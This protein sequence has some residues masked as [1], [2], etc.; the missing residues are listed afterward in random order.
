[1][2]DGYTPSFWHELQGEDMI[3]RK[4]GYRNDFLKEC[5]FHEPPVSERIK[6]IRE[7]KQK[8]AL[9]EDIKNAEQLL[10]PDTVA[11]VK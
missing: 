1:M 9:A 6:A 11:Q 4:C 10:Q 5:P 2:L 3:C 7:R 8:E